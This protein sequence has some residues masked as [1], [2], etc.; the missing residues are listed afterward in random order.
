M[1]HTASLENVQAMGPSEASPALVGR[2]PAAP[3][4]TLEGEREWLVTNARGSFAHGTVD[5]VLRRKYHS[6][7]SVRRAGGAHN[8]LAEVLE[9]VGTG[10]AEYCL[11]AIGRDAETASKRPELQA[12]SCSGSAVW[13]Y[14]LGSLRLRRELTLA[15]GGDCV[16]I[17]YELFGTETVD[18]SLEPLLLFRSVHAV[19]Q[20]DLFLDGRVRDEPDGYSIAPYRGSPRLYFSLGGAHSSYEP[21]GAF[22]E[23]VH[24]W[25]GARGYERGEFA[26]APGRLHLRLHPD[27]PVVLRLG[28][29]PQPAAGVVALSREPASGPRSSSL[30][31]I[32]SRS[33][34]S[35]VVQSE[36]GPSL[37]SGYPW[38]GESAR[39][40][41]L[42]LPGLL[43]AEP[44]VFVGVLE[45]VGRSLG[46]RTRAGTAS[47]DEAAD[48]PLLFIRAV[49]LAARAGYGSRAAKLVETAESLLRGWIEGTHPK[50]RLSPAGLLFAAPGPW[51]LTWMNAT[52]DGLPV[53]A[54]SGYA[55]DVNALFIDALGFL[56]RPFASTEPPL[57]PWAS[58]HERAVAA[59]RNTFCSSRHGYLADCH[60]GETPDFSLRPNQLWA[61]A[62][63][64]SPLSRAERLAVVDVVKEHLL[65]EVG[66]RTL[67]PNDP[68]YRGRCEGDAKCRDGAAHQGSAWPF[69]LG[70]YADALSNLG[71]KERLR[72]DLL[73]V[74][75][76]LE[77][78]VRS[79]AC[80]GQISELFDGG[81]PHEPRGA[82]AHAASAA[83]VLRVARMV[84][85]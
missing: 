78:H 27:E 34:Q 44:A 79:E 14:E 7:L 59:F 3:L 38:L 72:E 82:P 57:E 61:A 50:V 5:R 25:E 49:Q 73:P 31:A 63:T 21:K 28:T 41:L 6:L 40:A 64:H 74:L 10:D 35:F 16:L 43:V 17:R 76:R 18:L 56:A 81:A 20:K 80:L 77:H 71:E 22:R 24:E 53:T 8:L 85:R 47:S 46:G 32:L 54:R 52:D 69:L 33:L 62:L 11:P 51:A 58:L 36:G 30:S 65:T 9:R 42:A 67:S 39:Q 1:T 45:A 83:E 68:R 29:E 4:R 60:D 84:E 13:L 55:V 23:L 48:V 70:L 37:I 12:F 19:A 66:V 15:P 75:A 26:F 2:A